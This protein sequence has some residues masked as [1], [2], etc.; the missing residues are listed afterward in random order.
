M[1]SVQSKN[2]SIRCFRHFYTRCD[3]SSTKISD[4][5]LSKEEKKKIFPYP[6]KEDT[7]HTHAHTI[8]SF[9]NTYIR[10]SVDSER[11]MENINVCNARVRF[12]A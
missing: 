1:F 7:E 2:N 11:T 4:F 8:M 9:D 10:I 5:S 3:R 12:N 6:N